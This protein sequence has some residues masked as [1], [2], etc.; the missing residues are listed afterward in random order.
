MMADVD[1]LLNDSFNNLLLRILISFPVQQL[2]QLGFFFTA[3]LIKTI[4]QMELLFSVLMMHVRTV[5]AC[6]LGI[7]M[8]RKFSTK[9]CCPAPLKFL[10]RT[11]NYFG[12]SISCKTNCDRRTENSLVE[13]YIANDAYENAFPFTVADSLKLAHL[14]EQCIEFGQH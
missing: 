3:E 2:F 11:E 12:F 13:N 5:L 8:L 7:K 1:S 6:Q 10:E 9:K 4:K 14:V